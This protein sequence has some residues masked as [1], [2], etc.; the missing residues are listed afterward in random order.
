MSSDRSAP[1]DEASRQSPL[2]S[3][4]RRDPERLCM[5]CFVRQQPN[6]DSQVRNSCFQILMPITIM[7]MQKTNNMMGIL[8]VWSMNVKS[9][10]LT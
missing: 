7:S 9:S 4:W 8:Q 3:T 6:I 10:M 2:G 5:Q 1:T